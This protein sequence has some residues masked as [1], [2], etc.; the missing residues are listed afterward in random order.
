MAQQ[1]TTILCP[2]DFDDNSMAALEVAANLARKGGGRLVAL[3]VVPVDLPPTRK[4][5]LDF[6]EIKE[7]GAQQWLEG[8]AREHLQGVPH[9][10]L[11]RSGRPEVAILHAA[12][13][14]R[15]DLI[16]MATHARSIIPHAFCGSVAERVLCQSRR[17]V[18][19]VPATLGGNVDLVAAWM[20]LHP[21]TVGP[22]SKLADVAESMRKG[23]FHCMPVMDDGRLVGVITDHDIRS[24]AGELEDV[25]VRAAMTSE[26]VAIAPDTSVQ[27]AARLLIE[28]KVGALPVLKDSGLVGIMTSEDI[29]K[30]VL[31]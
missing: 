3:H 5:D 26:V 4:V 25:E 15:A 13:E 1:F 29:L 10:L 27:E 17:P 31:R 18:L 6:L 14:C 8:V 24:H 23:G 20:T 7:K 22:G 9:E 28:C 2:V 16:V 21:E 11:S 30:F 12:E 19:M